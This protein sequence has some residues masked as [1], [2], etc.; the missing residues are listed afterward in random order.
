MF[1]TTPKFVTVAACDHRN[2]AVTVPSFHDF[3]MGIANC[4]YS[5]VVASK[6]SVTMSGW[7]AAEAI[8]TN[9]AQPPV[10]LGAM[11][12]A[13]T[14]TACF[15]AVTPTTAPVAPLTDVTNPPATGGTHAAPSQ[16]YRPPS[17]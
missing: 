14:G 11:A 3:G 1:Q 10:T 16:A 15:P 8:E 6:S 13:I 17:S 4:A 5:C 2:C 9:A 7:F 12:P